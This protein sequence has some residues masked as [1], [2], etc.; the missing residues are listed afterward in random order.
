MGEE[1][2]E[3]SNN[4]KNYGKIVLSLENCQI[5][6]DK[7]DGKKLIFPFQKNYI[8]LMKFRFF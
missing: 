6:E 7:L 8:N 4:S 3:N 5:P 1:T 2:K